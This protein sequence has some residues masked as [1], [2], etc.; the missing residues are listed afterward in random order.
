MGIFSDVLLVSDFDR[1][2]TRYDGTIPE[3]NL[4]AIAQ[5]MQQ[6]GVFTIATGRSLPLFRQRAKTLPLKVPVLLYNGGAC[7]DFGKEK[8]EFCQGMPLELRPLVEE[9]QRKYPH[10]RA[11]I[12]CLDAHYAF[13]QD[14][15]RD[16][17]LKKS[18]VPVRYS[19]WEQIPRPWVK[20]SFYAPFLQ[21]GH[22]LPQDAS[23]EDEK[24]F[25]EICQW[26]ETNFSGVYTA[27]RAL[28]RMVEIERYGISK[29]AGARQL[30]NVLNRSV[31]VC[32]GDAP[33]DLSML[34]EAD[35]AYIPVD[36]DPE[37]LGRGFHMAAAC[38]VG[39]IADV[40][41]KLLKRLVI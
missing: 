33:N 5:F 24:P 15:L 26:V 23:K 20:A 19:T 37:M 27:T 3:E 2:L 11:E 34:Q 32:V 17:Y 8:L 16:E 9:I 18:G 14:P 29:G 28:P 6:G 7:Y 13:G 41:E 21:A 12:Q 1:T 38:D 40:I 30:A 39:T 36:C 25:V 31:L 35:L 4:Q 10:L 22:C